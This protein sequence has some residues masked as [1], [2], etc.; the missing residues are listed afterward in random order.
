MW[1]RLAVFFVIDKTMKYRIIK[2]QD[3]FHDKTHYEVQK[4]VLWWWW[5]IDE[6][7]CCIDG[8]HGYSPKI[9]KSKEDAQKYIDGYETRTI[10]TY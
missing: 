2:V 5:T 6:M 9:F 10:I 1:K 4:K 8:L 7:W 3:S